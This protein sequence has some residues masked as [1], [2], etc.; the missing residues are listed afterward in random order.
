[1]PEN[2]PYILIVDDEPKIRDILQE[3]LQ[4][5]GYVT[6]MAGNGREALSLFD[7]ES[8]DLVILDLVMPDMSGMDVLRLLAKRAP[9]VPVIIISAHGNIPK[10]VEATQLGAV[11]FLEKPVDTKEL[12]ACIKEQLAE[13]QKQQ[14]FDEEIENNFLRYGFIG[15][16]IL[17]QDVFRTIDQS[18]STSIRVL[19]TGATG[20]GKEL[21]AK[22]IHRL[23]QRY[24]KPFIKVN[25][26]AI[27][28]ELIESELFGH[29]KGSFTGAFADKQGR[30][31]LAHKGTLFL[32]EVADMSPMTQAKVLRALEDGEIQAV[33]ST[34]IKQVDVRVITATNRNLPRMVKEGAFRED[35]FYRL[36]VV[37][38]HLPI[39]EKR[40][41]DISYLARH[42]LSRYCEDFNS[43]LKQIT[44]RGM[45]HLIQKKWP[46]NI[47]QLRNFIEKLVVMSREEIIDVQDILKIEGREVLEEDL[48]AVLTLRDARQRFEKDFILSKL[49]AHGWKVSDVAMELD[50]ERTALYRKLKELDIPVRSNKPSG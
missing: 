22:A 35:L 29:K 26:A 7:S 48:E 24:D 16:S 47:R 14:T 40:K 39:L 17:L 46:G 12:I 18:A 9:S 2:R 30:F 31:A 15:G 50:V 23:S 43:P 27:P 33:G 10:A 21:A 49:I 13:T 5:E 20:T 37:N 45:T 38:L 6:C 11:E 32:D 28:E 4:N 41:E 8:I 34:S 42:F 44:K 25:C 1:M 19:I 3:I 36:N